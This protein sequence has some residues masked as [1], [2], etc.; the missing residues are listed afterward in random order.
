MR[1]L[2]W[3]IYAAP[4]SRV[5]LCIIMMPLLWI[6]LAQQCVKQ[7]KTRKIWE[8]LN[9]LLVVCALGIILYMTV[10]SRNSGENEVFLVPFHAFREARV[11]KEMY[12][13][14]LMNV[15]LFVPAGLS[16][17]YVIRH[18]PGGSVSEKRKD[19]RAAIITVILL[20]FFSILIEWLQY[21]YALGRVETDDVLCNTL[22][23]CFGVC[24][25]WFR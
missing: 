19:R 22:G 4:L 14:M 1:H 9:L 11:Q 23:A 18:F 7:E 10:S 2:T 21:R 13:S 6:R 16:L 3:M 17:P 15:L 5:I 20:L 8:V 25:I 24:G 12:R